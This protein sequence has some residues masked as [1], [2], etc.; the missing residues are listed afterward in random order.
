MSTHGQ[1]SPSHTRGRLIWV[2]SLLVMALLLR[3]FVVQPHH[4]VSGSMMPT[5]AVGDRLVVD[6]L[7]FR[8]HPPRAGDVVVFEP[9]PELVRSGDLSGHSSI[10]RVIALPG[11][12]VRV[13][14]GQVFVDGRLLQEPY[15]AQAPAYEWG[16]ARVP[17]DRLFVL[18]DNRNGSSDSHVWGVLPMRSVTGRAWLRFW[19]PA[20]MGAL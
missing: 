15:V 4:I 1:V 12:E 17:E 11:Q 13:H 6:K 9:P 8:L 16:P 2:G 20:R 10:K 5:L 14:G 7:S 3:G 19:P 18:G